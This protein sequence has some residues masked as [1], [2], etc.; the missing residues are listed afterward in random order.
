MAAPKTLYTCR[1]CGGTSPKW[2]GQCPHC[3]AWNTLD[4]TAAEPAGASRNRFQALA[5]AAGQRQLVATLS[6]I[7]AAEV[8]RTPT[9]QDELDRVLAHHPEAGTGWIGHAHHTL[10]VSPHGDHRSGRARHVAV[11]YDTGL[12]TAAMPTE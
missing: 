1:E 12:K 7:E 10:D 8:E 3:K 4:E 5:G 6:E 11:A 2:L 9:G